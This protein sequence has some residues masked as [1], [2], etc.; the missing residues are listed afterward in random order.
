MAASARH[1]VNH[2]KKYTFG[3]VAYLFGARFAAKRHRSVNH[4][5]QCILGRD[6]PHT[7]V[8]YKASTTSIPL[9]LL[10]LPM[11]RYD[12]RCTRRNYSGY[13]LMFIIAYNSNAVCCVQ[14]IKECLYMC[15]C[16]CCCREQLITRDFC[17]DAKA[18][19]DRP[20]EHHGAPSKKVYVFLNPQANYQ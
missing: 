12:T 3:T 1:F 7:L 14:C 9:S 16:T 18:L 8:A 4:S 6:K 13:E 19:A 10:T 15:V 5:L 17:K 20:C 2:W 11:A